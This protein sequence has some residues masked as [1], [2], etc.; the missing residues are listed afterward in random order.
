MRFYL[1]ILLLACCIGMASAQDDKPLIPDYNNAGFAFGGFDRTYSYVT[2]DNYDAS[3]SYPLV[4]VFHGAGST[5]IDMMS[6]T[7]L[8]ELAAKN[9]YI[10]AFPDGIEQ[11]WGYLNKEDQDSRDVYTE[12]WNFFAALVDDV[13]A[14]ASVDAKRVYVIG[15]SNGG[16]L[17]YRIMCEQADRVAGVVVLASTLST[18]TADSCVG[19]APVPLMMVLGTGDRTFPFGGSAEIKGKRLILQLSF[20]QQMTFLAQ[21]QQCKLSGGTTGTVSVPGSQFE[22]VRDFYN[23]CPGGAPILV[24]AMIDFEHGYGGKAAIIRED[25]TAGT[26]ED[27]MFDFFAAYPA[28]AK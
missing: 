14:H 10:I 2:P 21:H 13:A 3:K 25:G 4:V 16:S 24:Y 18:Y 6:H 15:L 22:V 11:G 12:D 23:E 9:G 27:A 17:A 19:T 1:T 28:P 5:G 26:L 20:Q 8:K 7:G